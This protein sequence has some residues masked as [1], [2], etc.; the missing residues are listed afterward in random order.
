M[1]GRNGRG[2]PADLL[3]FLST[4]TVHEKQREEK[5]GARERQALCGTTVRL[6][7]SARIDTLSKLFPRRC[8]LIILSL[9]RRPFI[10]FLFPRCVCVCVL[11]S[12]RLCWT[13]RFT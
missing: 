9:P 5:H 11:L 3:R 7:D 8:P 6:L 2:F 12:C 4:A 1:K 10:S 13:F